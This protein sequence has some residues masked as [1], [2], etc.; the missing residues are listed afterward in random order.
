M[1]AGVLARLVYD[2]QFW[3]E[4]ARRTPVCLVCDEAHL[5]MPVDAGSGAAHREGL[6]AFEAIAKEGRKHGVALLVVS[7]RPADVSQTILSQCNNFVIMRLT[8]DRDR[9]MV[10]R[11]MPEALAGIAGMLPALNV[12]EAIVVGDAVLLPNPLRFD[13]PKIKPASSTQPY[14]TLW[15]HDSS[16]PD[17]IASGVEALRNQMRASS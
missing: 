7:Q 1:V 10:E 12:G 8:N 16:G 15:T 3:T 4:P 17:V 9:T 6:E 11:V 2:I 13:P 5:Y 14:W